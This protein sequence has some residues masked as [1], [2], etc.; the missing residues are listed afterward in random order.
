MPA[1]VACGCSALAVLSSCDQL[2][3]TCD[4]QE[5]AI[6]DKCD[7]SAFGSSSFHIFGLPRIGLPRN[8]LGYLS[9]VSLVVSPNKLGLR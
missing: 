8:K 6:R 5:G 4:C 7:D 2:T 9:E 3:G 1:C